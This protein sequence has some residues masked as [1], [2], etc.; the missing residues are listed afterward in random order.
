M[1][2]GVI[3]GTEALLKA[4][5]MIINES[6]VARTLTTYTLQLFDIEVGFL[7]LCSP[8]GSSSLPLP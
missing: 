7:C 6:L 3:T 2:T 4:F 5:S 8:E 1:R